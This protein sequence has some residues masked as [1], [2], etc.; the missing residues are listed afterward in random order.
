MEALS[1]S[2]TSILTRA[3]RRNIP[4]GAILRRKYSSFTYPLLQ[5][6]RPPRHY[7]QHSFIN[8]PFLFSCTL[9]YNRLVSSSLR[10][11]ISLSFLPF[12]FFLGMAG[13]VGPVSRTLSSL[14]V[15]VTSH[16]Q[17]YPEFCCKH[18]TLDRENVTCL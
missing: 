1:S 6:H 7:P 17:C 2:E 9:S 18:M 13:C 15:W 5:F 11:S 8:F 4:E 10:S 14:I 12:T 16:L 3:S